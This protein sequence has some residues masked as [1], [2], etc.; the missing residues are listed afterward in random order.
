MCNWTGSEAVCSCPPGFSGNGK[1]SQCIDIN[2]C[3]Q[4]PCPTGSRCV[5]QAG[6][7]FC[8]CPVGST[9]LVDA[10][11]QTCQ[12]ITSTISGVVVSSR[13]KHLKYAN[14]Q[15]RQILFFFLFLLCFCTN[16]V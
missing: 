11:N 15:V 1:T 5:N 9:M 3:H 7:Y 2:E 10:N 16:L 14:K 12:Q 8:S 13:N 6:G 4:S